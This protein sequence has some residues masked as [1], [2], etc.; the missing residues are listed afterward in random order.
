MEELI[1]ML[2]AST[3]FSVLSTAE[4]EELADVFEPTHCSLGQTVV[5]TGDDSD[6]FYLV[7]S[8]RAEVVAERA[9][10]E[11]V[12]GTLNRGDHFGEQGL[13]RSARREFTVRALDSLVLLRLWKTDF[14]RLLAAHPDVASY[15]EQYISEVSIRN[16]LKLCTIF[17]PLSDA[18]IRDLLGCLET[19]E[20]VEKEVIVREGDS[21]D[22]FYILRS[23]AATVVK[24]SQGGRVVNRLQPGDFFGELALLTGKPRAATVIAEEAAIVFRLEKRDFDRLLMPAP[25]A[26]QA[27]SAAALGYSQTVEPAPESKAPEPPSP[28]YQ[29]KHARRYPCSAAGVRGGMRRGVPVV[30]AALLQEGC[31]RFP[32]PHARARG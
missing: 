28:A 1:G 7:Y 2:K 27:F 31:E 16:F 9:A 22:A 8:G 30:H 13:V 23:G 20:Y 6:A 19:R 17:A 3:V 15:F 18:A 4:L 12:V 32:H 11:V 21:G 5:R 26:R 29:P 25:D 10:D 24:K 14:E